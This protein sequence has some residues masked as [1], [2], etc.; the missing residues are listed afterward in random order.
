[1]LSDLHFFVWGMGVSREVIK[2]DEGWCG[3]EWGDK[4]WLIKGG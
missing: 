2:G 1:M 4:G 3:I